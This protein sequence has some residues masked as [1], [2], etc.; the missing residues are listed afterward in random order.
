[1]H[2]IALTRVVFVTFWGGHPIQCYATAQAWVGPTETQKEHCLLLSL[3]VVN[4]KGL[5]IGLTASLRKWE[6]HTFWESSDPLPQ[7]LFLLRR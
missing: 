4:G 2:L 3:G 7:N 1:M 6:V 5:A